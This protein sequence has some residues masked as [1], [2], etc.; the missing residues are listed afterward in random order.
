MKYS[1]LLV[2]T[3][4]LSTVFLFGNFNIVSGPSDNADITWTITTYDF[5]KIPMSKP[6]SAEF[7]F[8]NP[9]MVPLIISSVKPSC[10]CTVADYP[11]E[12]IA[13]GKK[14]KIIVG[15]NAATPGQFQKSI[16]VQ[17]NTAE[18]ITMLIIKGEVVK[19]Q[20]D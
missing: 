20:A 19:E 1:R 12:P 4:L 11:K 2:M 15:Y 13:P 18:S 9:S 5:G 14:G 8:L 3:T 7:E 6:A 10:G 16:R 17:T